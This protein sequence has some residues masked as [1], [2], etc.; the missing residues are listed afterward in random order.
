MTR[1]DVEAKGRKS[2]NPYTHRRYL[3]AAALGFTGVLN[4]DAALIGKSAEYIHDGLAR[5]DPAGFNLEKKGYDS[6]YHAVGLSFAIRYYSIVADAGL[7]H[8]LEPMINKG[9][10]WLNTRIEPDGSV[11]STGNTRTGLGQEVG[12][13]LKTK[14]MSY[15][16]AYRAYAE[17]GMITGDKALQNT[18]QKLASCDRTKPRPSK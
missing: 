3:V 18:A 8:E 2:N 7:R 12:R 5:Q 4:N 1:P 13:N 17:W 14:T 6:S 11:D 10:A 9:L 16:S 15:G